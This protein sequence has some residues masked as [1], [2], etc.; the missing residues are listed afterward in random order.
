MSPK[1]FYVFLVAFVA[2]F[3]G[4]LFGYDTGVISGAILFISQEFHLSSALNG[5][6][7]SSVLMGACVGALLSGRMTDHVGRKMML[8]FDALL[9]MIGSLMTSLAATIAFL[10]AGRIVVG[11]AIGIASFTAPLYISEIAPKEH[12]GA[13]VSLN[14]L[15]I[16]AG[17]FISYLV[18][19][20]FAQTQAWRWMF[21]IGIIPSAFL[22]V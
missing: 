14:Q 21:G 10:V 11:I 20:A 3:S 12:R 7:V 22:F 4:I 6:V 2:A 8:I 17:I 15:A 13:L 16:A 18:D 9:F 19:Y 1:S 5:F